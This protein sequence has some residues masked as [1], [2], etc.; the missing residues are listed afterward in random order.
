[1]SICTAPSCCTSTASPND[2]PLASLMLAVALGLACAGPASN[3]AH[4]SAAAAMVTLIAPSSTGVC[5]IDA[6]DITEPRRRT[7]APL[8]G[9]DGHGGSLA[10][11]LHYRRGME[12]PFQRGELVTLRQY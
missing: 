9:K 7:S 3:D 2:L 12:E 10:T 1:M 8:G 5:A 4:A 11:P 6:S